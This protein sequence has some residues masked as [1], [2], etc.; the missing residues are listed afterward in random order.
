MADHKLQAGMAPYRGSQSL[1][2]PAAAAVPA[3][4]EYNGQSQCFC[5][6]KLFFHHAAVQRKFPVIAHQSASVTDLKL[7]NAKSQ[8]FKEMPADI[9]IL[10]AKR[11]VA[12]CSRESFRIF[13]H[14]FPCIEILGADKIALEHHG[15][16]HAFP[17]H[18]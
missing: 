10:S 8:I 3:D 5:I 17:V 1:R 14:C 4:I 12:C 7:Y 16:F 9:L 15:F 13:L 11:V 6:A 2:L 18:Q